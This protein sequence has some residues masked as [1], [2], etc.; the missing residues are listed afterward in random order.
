MSI[1][2]SIKK[3]TDNIPNEDSYHTEQDFIAISDGAGGCGV[4][5]HEWSEY[6]VNN[7]PINQPVKSYEELDK[8]VGGIWESFYQ[9]HESIA[10]K[11]YDCMFQSKFYAEGSCATI[12]AVWR[13]DSNHCHWMTYG[14]SVVFHYNKKTKKLEHSFTS[15]ADFSKSPYLISCKDPMQKE[16]F[17]TG[18]FTIDDDS[19]VFA[20]SDALSHYVLMMYMVTDYDRYKQELAAIAKSQS[21]YS[22]MIGIAKSID[23]VNFYIDVIRKLENVVSSS[24]EDFARFIKELHERGLI[25]IDDYTLV[26]LKRD[27]EKCNIH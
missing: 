10:L 9:S 12:A 26:F 6:L 7:L 8:W 18:S 1:G 27:D 20:C 16:G 25:E 13:I 22:T 3:I 21:T 14:D 24:E 4:F 11:D 5:A 17:R 15:L 23:E 19:V 2:I